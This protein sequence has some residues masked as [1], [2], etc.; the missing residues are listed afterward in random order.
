MSQET[1]TTRPGEPVSEVIGRLRP[2]ED[3]PEQAYLKALR[4]IAEVLLN[5][6]TLFIAGEPYRLTEIEAYWS[7]QQHRDPFSHGDEI[8]L[9][10]GRWYFHRQDGGQYKG[11]SFKGLD[12][13]FGRPGAFGGLL[14]RGARSLKG[15]GLILDGPCLLVDH[16]LAKSGAKSIAALLN[17]WSGRID[18]PSEGPSPL[19]LEISAEHPSEELPV[20][21]SPRV[22]LTLKKGP[23]VERQRFVARPYRFA[24][25]PKDIKKG[26]ANTVVGL[27]RQGVPTSEIATISGVSRSNVEKYQSAYEAGAHRSPEDLVGELSTEELCALFGACDARFSKEYE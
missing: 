12:I 6:A 16:I 18:R 19:A 15:S 8:Q 22:G 21:E 17:G 9:D 26:R 25:N 7:S 10:L 20:F 27:I 3:A 23:T 13:A 2:P 11:G 4:P 24:T 1:V 5:R 14:L